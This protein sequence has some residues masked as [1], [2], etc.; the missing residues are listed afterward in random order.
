MTLKDNGLLINI[1]ADLKHIEVRTT[2][3]AYKKF[4]VHWIHEALFLVSSSVVAASFVL[5]HPPESK[6]RNRYR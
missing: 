1:S 4:A 3:C 5:R 6:A 2:N